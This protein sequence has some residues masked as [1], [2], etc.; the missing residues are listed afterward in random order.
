MIQPHCDAYEILIFKLSKSFKITIEMIIVISILS[1]GAAAQY[2]VKSAWRFIPH[3]CNM[4]L[5]AE[6]L[7]AGFLM[8]LLFYKAFISC[9]FFIYTF[10]V[11]EL[12]YWLSFQM[13]HYCLQQYFEQEKKYFGHILILAVGLHLWSSG[14][15]LPAQSPFVHFRRLRA[16]TIWPAGMKRQDKGSK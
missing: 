3:S 5:F 11:R 10:S 12:Q 1:M 13:W 15:C 8:S 4:L 9:T 6:T 2:G 14:H 16:S 7:L